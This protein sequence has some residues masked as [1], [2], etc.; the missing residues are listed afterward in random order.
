MVVGR[1]PAN[2]GAGADEGGYGDGDSKPKLR[3]IQGVFAFPHL[4]EW[5]DAI[6]AKMVMKVGDRAYWE[7]WAKDIAKIATTHIGRTGK[8]RETKKRPQ[9]LF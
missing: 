4:D 7:T 2:R 5:K 8:T 3:D 9:A 1:G 6:Y